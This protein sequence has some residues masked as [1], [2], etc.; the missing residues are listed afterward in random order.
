MDPDHVRACLRLHLADGVGA[1][2]FRRLVDAYGSAQAAREA[3]PGAWRGVEGIGPEKAAAIAAVT[4]EQVE[5][6]AELQSY[7]R[8]SS[9]TLFGGETVADDRAVPPLP[10]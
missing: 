8:S 5:E 9:G 4:D 3:G 2:L 10:P 1:I 7:L 6:V